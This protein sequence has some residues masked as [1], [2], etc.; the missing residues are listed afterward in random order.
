M[1]TRDV[2]NDGATDQPDTAPGKQNPNSYYYWHSHEKER[3]K[4]GDVAPKITPTL[5]KS[6]LAIGFDAAVR[7]QPIAKYSWCNNKSSVSVHFDFDGLGLLA[8]ASPDNVSVTFGE[9][10]LKVVIRDYS[11][12]EHHVALPLTKEIDPAASSFRI[13][14]DQLVVKLSKKDLESTWYDLVDT[15][16]SVDAKDE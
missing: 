2:E 1:S 10:S 9:K 4:V 3:A 5:V 6:E 14:P 11:S 8:A 13:K 16:G 12:G 7:R 15:K